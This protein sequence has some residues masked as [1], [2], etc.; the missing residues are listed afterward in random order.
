MLTRKVFLSFLLSVIAM[1]SWSQTFIVSEDIKLDLPNT[2]VILHSGNAVLFKYDNWVLSHQ[3]LDPSTFYPSIDLTGLM[4]DFIRSIFEPKKAEL[5]K[6]LQVIAQE[7]ANAFNVSNGET[8]NFLLGKFEVYSVY[9]PNEKKGHL[10]LIG[11]DYVSHFNV[12]A[13]KKEFL[14]FL[15]ILKGSF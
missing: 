2:A 4:S 10:F 12:L 13:D 15:E 8:Q 14:N 3:V 9:D 7:Q 11:K 5:P 1:H 6:W